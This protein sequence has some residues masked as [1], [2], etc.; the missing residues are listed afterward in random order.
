MSNYDYIH[1]WIP[2]KELDYLI[3]D[4]QTEVGDNKSITY[5]FLISSN[6]G[7]NEVRIINSHH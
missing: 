5:T 6:E 4:I 1:L 2:T 3:N 7:V